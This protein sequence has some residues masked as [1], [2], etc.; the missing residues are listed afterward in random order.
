[1]VGPPSGENQMTVFYF[2]MYESLRM[3]RMIKITFFVA[4][5]SILS[6]RSYANFDDKPAE[7]I[8]I[9]ERIFYNECGN[10]ISSLIVWNDGES[11]PSLGIGHFIWYPEG[12][13][14]PFDESF[15]R[16]L[17]FIEKKGVVLPQ[18]IQAL[19][20]RYAPWRKRADF[21]RDLERGQLEELRSFLMETK[22]LQAEFMA[23]RF[24][25]SIP[26]ILHAAPLNKRLEIKQKL[27]SILQSRQGLYP[28]I[29]YV[30]FNG[31]GVLE[32]ERYKGKGWGLLQ[33]LEEMKIPQQNDQ[34]VAEF[35]RGAERVLR[36]RVANSPPERNEK[37]WL[38]GWENRIHTYGAAYDDGETVVDHNLRDRLLLTVSDGEKR[39]SDVDRV[40][41]TK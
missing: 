29:D 19:P 1:M 34:A 17:S 15:P 36:R 6:L 31:E 10:K 27:V 3:I 24:R 33:V 37:R 16:L 38:P 8:G 7:I 40:N 35:M 30:N 2:K 4:L 13:K 28:L 25:Q 26:K 9:S 23:E 11:F 12:Y 21:I 41:V 14:G 32:S 5:F 39:T 20:S 18:W 22:G